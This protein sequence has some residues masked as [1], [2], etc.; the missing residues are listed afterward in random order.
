MIKLKLNVSS[1]SVDVYVTQKLA[2]RALDLIISDRSAVINHLGHVYVQN[3]ILSLYCQENDIH[4][5]A[6]AL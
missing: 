1:C 3:L 5:P 6:V 4:Q 2:R